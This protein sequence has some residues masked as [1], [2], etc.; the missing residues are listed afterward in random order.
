MTTTPTLAMPNFNEPFIIESDASVDGIGAVLTQHSRP[1]AFMSRALGVAKKSWSVYAKEML[2]IVHAV[3]TWRPYLLGRKFY[4]HTD[5]CSLKHLLNSELSLRNSRNGWQNWLGMSMKLD[6]TWEDS[7]L[8]KDRF[9]ILKL[10][11]KVAATGGGID[12]AR[13]ST[14]VPKRNL[15]IVYVEIGVVICFQPTP[16]DHVEEVGMI[17]AFL[18]GYGLN[19]CG[20]E[21]S[22][23]FSIMLNCGVKP[24]D[25][26]ILFVL[27][28]CCQ[29]GLEHEGAILRKLLNFVK[30]MPLEPDKRI[31]GAL[32]AGCR[33]K[34]D[35]SIA[36]AKFVVQQL[37]AS[38][39]E[40]TG[41]DFIRHV[42]RRGSMERCGKT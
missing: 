32:L 29:Y 38:D 30:E 4:I 28:T 41:Y 12:A 10:E 9:P 11:D 35:R 24:D 13:H 34:R 36:V 5:Q 23:I 7:Q 15:K 6:A 18:L 27:S 3:C 17:V 39:T 20:L 40:N 25:A 22:E 16:Q 42:C 1:I 31:W 14:R 37:T 33:S 19:G 26:V 21:A 8:I 2:T